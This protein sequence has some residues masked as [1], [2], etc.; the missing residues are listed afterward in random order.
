MQ[1]AMLCRV[2]RAM[3]SVR[4]AVA[5]PLIP[6]SPLLLNFFWKVIKNIMTTWQSL[7]G[8]CPNRPYIFLSGASL[9]SLLE[10]HDSI[11]WRKNCTLSVE[12]HL[13]SEISVEILQKLWKK[14]FCKHHGVIITL[15][16]SLDTVLARW[17][18]F[19]DDLK[20]TIQSIFLITHEE[21]FDSFEVQPKKSLPLLLMQRQFI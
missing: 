6:I 19:W 4:I 1:C 16:A 21:Y 17:R 9:T 15:S 3:C 20:N 14:D 10:H 7:F 8:Q 2:Q 5:L 18:N 12:L 11:M 13:L